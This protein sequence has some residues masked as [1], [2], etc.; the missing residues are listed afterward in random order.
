MKLFSALYARVIRWSK[1]PQAPA[2]LGLVSFTE[3]SFFPIPPDVMLVSMGLAKPARV[4]FYTFITFI[5]SIL[6][7]VLGYAIGYF[8]LDNIYP[9][10]VYLNYESAYN[11]VQSWFH[12]W[13]FWS[14]VIAAFTPIPFKVFTIAAGAVHMNMMQF[15]L[16]CFL[17][18]ACRF[19]LL[20][21][22]LY[23]FGQKLDQLLVKSIDILGWIVIAS[24]VLAY[25]ISYW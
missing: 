23:F 19:Y 21:G 10:I 15:L 16:G 8:L 20:G 24:L 13:G 7:A 25:V 2:I 18:R 6:G 4:L 12:T 22:L 5:C 14:M 17:G 9:V 11:T 3:A 1:H